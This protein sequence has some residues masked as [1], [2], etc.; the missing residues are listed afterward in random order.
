M[1]HYLHY[2]GEYLVP[3]ASRTSQAFSFASNLGI[4][5]VINCRLDACSPSPGDCGFRHPAA[6]LPPFRK[7]YSLTPTSACVPRTWPAGWDVGRRFNPLYPTNKQQWR[8]RRA[9]RAAV[10][11]PAARQK[12][13][14]CACACVGGVSLRRAPLSPLLRLRSLGCCSCRCSV[15]ASVRPP[16]RPSVSPCVRLL[17]RR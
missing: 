9:A 1:S 6:V 4:R 2:L 14:A 17:V 5:V 15:T 7:W 3:R 12:G 8:R 13:C 10:A 16:V 11:R